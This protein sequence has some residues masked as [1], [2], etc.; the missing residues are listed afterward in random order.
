MI[1]KFFTLIISLV[2]L[3]GSISKADEGMWLPLL[4]KQLN[5][6]D[7]QKMGLKL[8]ADDIYNVNKSSLKDAIVHFGGFCTGEMISGDGLILTNH[9]CGFDAIQ[10]HSSV[11]KDYITNGFWAMTRDQELPNPGLFVR[12]LVSIEDVTAKVKAQIPADLDESKRGA[13]LQKIFG[14]MTKAAKGE[15]KYDVEIRSFFN[16][17]EFYMFTYE[18][19]T[20]VRLVGA[21]PQSIGNFGG[22]T[23]NWMWP[24]HTGDFSM[25]R[26]YCSK[27]GKPADYSKDNVPY[28]PKHFLP[29]STAGLQP[30]DF[31]M[32]FGYPGR[33]DR[34]LSSFGVDQAV[35]TTSPATVKIRTKKLD[36][37]K[38]DMD[39]SDAV[40]IQYAA[41]YAQTSNYWKYFIGQTKGL[42]RM[43]V[44][45]Q[46]AAEEQS[47]QNWVNADPARKAKYGNVIAGLKKS[48]EDL[49]KY[50]L[51]RTYLNEAITRGPEIL[52]FAYSH[53]Q[54]MKALENK[55]SK[56]EDINKIKEEILSRAD[57][58]FK[59]YNVP[60]D[61]KLIAVLMELFYNEV[62]K[63][64]HAPVFAEI[65]S[66]YKGDFNKYAEV[67]FEKSVFAN[68]AKYRSFMA[69]PSAKTLS[70]DPAYAAVNSIL[71]H[72]NANYK[73]AIAAITNEQNKNNRLFIEGLREMQSERKFAPDA[74]STMRL[75]YGKVKDYVPM[76]AVAYKHY[77]TAE[78]ILEKLDNDN[79]EFKVS[80]KLEK[81]I[82]DKDFGTY[83][84]NGNLKVCFISDNDI[85]GGNSGSP[86]INGSGSLVGL[87]FDGNWEA[88]S[89]DIAYDPVYKR[90]ISVDIRYVLFVIDKYA[91]AGHLIKEMKLVN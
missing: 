28:H 55:E 54:L 2:L 24:R 78:G 44:T 11:E 91:G 42:K 58:Y 5:E 72:Y 17:N 50:A 7:M 49:G 46:K 38:R 22:D 61:K 77:T 83:G 32:T 70:K 34:Y 36:V 12:Y 19:F 87:A 75:S 81:L 59:E 23:D 86:V 26:V 6:S 47:F 73:A 40:R 45:E 57:D 29:I 1:K 60:T 9:H 37:M 18:K 62:P 27:D 21:P 51:L 15:T 64:Q 74:N 35:S 4:L 76:D 90:T 71:D 63:D 82:R 8:T 3:A 89:G 52:M 14:V 67:M 39:A 84:E 80:P 85:T 88:M 79:D 31:T 56:P 33:T 53:Q 25:F 69:K 20:D 16:G 10:S 13:E 48:Y 68:E 43:R 30:G 66:K 65:Q 41:K